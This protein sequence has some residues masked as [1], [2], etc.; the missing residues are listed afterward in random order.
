MQ[1]ITVTY[2]I[3]FVIS[4]ATEYVFTKCNLCFNAKTGRK[5]KQVYNNGS[6]GYIIN[7]KFKSLKYLRE[8]L[9][10]PGLNSCPF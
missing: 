1:T 10:K 9:I 8:Y 5:I 6:I 4:F 7:G 2:T 3:K